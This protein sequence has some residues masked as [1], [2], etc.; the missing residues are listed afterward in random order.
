MV[1]PVRRG[2]AV[3]AQWT[4]FSEFEE[5]YDRMGRLLDVTFG[6]GVRGDVWTPLA[7][8]S[9]TEEGYVVEAEVPGMSRDDIDIRLDGN[10]LIISGETRE[11]GEPQEHRGR[12][13]RQR[14]RRYGRFEYRTTLPSD[15]DADRVDARLDNG[16]LTV[17]IARSDRARPRQIAIS[18]G[19]EQERR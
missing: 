17:S 18:G 12:R 2:R 9:E 4:P 14:T 1:L 5:L 10:E 3:P 8:V 15:I 19:G 6:E 11:A 7:D 13:V 16:V